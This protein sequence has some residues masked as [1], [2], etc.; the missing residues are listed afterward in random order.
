LVDEV[1]GGDDI[2]HF[3][4]MLCPGFVNA[5]CHLEP[6]GS[7]R[8]NDRIEAICDVGDGKQRGGKRSY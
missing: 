4:G 7:N 5:H 8:K 1:D 3:N 6:E 2:Q